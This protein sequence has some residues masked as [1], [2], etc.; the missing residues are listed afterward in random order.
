M[1]NLTSSRSSADV[2]DLSEAEYDVVHGKV[3]LCLLSKGHDAACN[4]LAGI[5]RGGV[6]LQVLQGHRRDVHRRHHADAQTEGTTRRHDEV[7]RENVRLPYMSDLSLN[8][9]G[10]ILCRG[11]RLAGADLLPGINETLKRIWGKDRHWT[12]GQDRT[13]LS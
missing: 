1:G 3:L 5:D 11:L 12:P 2:A 8:V 9:V 13:V 7:S 4:R 10:G 6:V